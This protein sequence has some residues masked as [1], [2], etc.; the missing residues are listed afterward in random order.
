MN[1][2][3]FD[4]AKLPPPHNFYAAQFTL[5]RS[6]RTWVNVSCPFHD[7]KRPSMSLNLESGAF[8]CHAC[9]VRGGDIVDFYMKKN[10]CNFKSAVQALGAWV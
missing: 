8:K 3:H 4:K 9:G 1:N 2:Q 7:D 5:R 6:T 10:D